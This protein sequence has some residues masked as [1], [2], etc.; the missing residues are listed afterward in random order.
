M[1]IIY[2]SKICKYCFK[3]WVT[4]FTIGSYV[5]TEYSEDDY[6]AWTYA[7]E[8]VHVRQYEEHGIIKFLWIY[9]WKERDIPY[10]E[11]TFEKE[12]YAVSEPIRLE[13]L[14]SIQAKA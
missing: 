3:E 2:N 10:R 6:P 1:K 7:H 4:A 13:H 8:E 12:A 14:R 5:F 11:R 9:F